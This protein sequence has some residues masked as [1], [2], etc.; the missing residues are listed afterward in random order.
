MEEEIK[1]GFVIRDDNAAEWALQKIFDEKAELERLKALADSQIA[2]IMD[3]VEAA[4]KR[5]TSRTG[6][7]KKALGEYMLIVSEQCKKTKTQLS[8]RLLSGSLIYKKPVVKIVKDDTKLLE[9]VKE[10]S[11][12]YVK[13]TEAVDWA[14]FK[15]TL[16]VSG[17]AVVDSNGEV[18]SCLD[19]EE[20]PG[21]FMIRDERSET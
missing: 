16:T 1:E 10:H 6:Y 11:P 5:F 19:V 17:D 7:L 15:K 8:Y 12:E 14:G 13:H 4:E 21:E 18:V 2:V 9:Y 20:T 3:K